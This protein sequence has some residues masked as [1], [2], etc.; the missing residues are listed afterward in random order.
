MVYGRN[1]LH[2]QT[3][4]LTTSKRCQATDQLPENPSVSLHG[5][6]KG[7]DAVDWDPVLPSQATLFTDEEKNS[8]GSI[9]SAAVFRHTSEDGDQGYPGT[10]LTEVLVGLLNP[11]Q[12]APPGPRDEYSLGSIIVV[13]RAKLLDSGKKTVTPINL[14]QVCPCQLI[15]MSIKLTTFAF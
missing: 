15:Q 3:V 2:K 11:G 4:R 1:L 8:M 10:L 14:T 7:F 9:S 13:Y 12:S 6:P 5:G